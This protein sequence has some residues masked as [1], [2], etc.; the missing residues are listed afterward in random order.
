MTVMMRRTSK[1]LVYEKL[2]IH[3][4]SVAKLKTIRVH[5]KN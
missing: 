5:F 4:A 3:N 1:C 2:L